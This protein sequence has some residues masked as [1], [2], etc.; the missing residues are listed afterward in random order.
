MERNNKFYNGIPHNDKAPSFRKETDRHIRNRK[1]WLLLAV[2]LSIVADGVVSA[3][4]GTATK[5]DYYWLAPLGLAIVDL[6]LFVDLFFVNL[7]Q[8]YA[9]AHRTLFVL[10][11]LALLAAS[12]V[13]P[14]FDP[15]HTVL[16]LVAAVLIGVVQTVKIVVVLILS[17]V[18]KH[19]TFDFARRAWSIALTLLVG[20][21]LTTYVGLNFEYGFMGQRVSYF[22]KKCTLVFALDE[23]D[24]Y[25]VVDCYADGNVIDVPQ[26]FNGKKVTSL[27][28]T[29]LQHDYITQIDLHGGDFYFAN[30]HL[31][32]LSADRELV[33]NA[34][35]DQV[36]ALRRSL[37]ADA[38]TVASVSQSAR[39][40]FNA[41]R[42]ADLGP[43]ETYY[44]ISF[45][46]VYPKDKLRYFATIIKRADEPFALAD[47]SAAEDTDYLA[48]NDLQSQADLQW[49][50]QYNDGYV[51]ADESAHDGKV[52]LAFEQVYKM[53]LGEGNDAVWHMPAEYETLY[54]ASSQLAERF[55]SLPR[56]DGFDV[57]WLA[58]TETDT[59]DSAQA[60][61]R[62]F[63][64]TA[65]T[66]VT[67]SPRWEVLP[68][69]ILEVSSDKDFAL[70]YGEDT[71]LT[72]TAEAALPVYYT[73]S[74]D[75]AALATSDVGSFDL[76][77]MRPADSGLYTI[78]AICKD[79]D[80]TSLVS[81][82][83]QYAFALQIS[84]RK[85]RLDWLLPDGEFDN[86]DRPIVCD[87]H[88]EDVI[89]GDVVGLALDKYSVF[90][91][92][93]YTVSA[94]LQKDDAANYY[95]EQEDAVQTFSVLPKTIDVVWTDEGEYVYDGT[96]LSPIA[97]TSVFGQ[98]QRLTVMGAGVDAGE[99]IATALAI[100][101]NYTI[102][103]GETHRYTILPKPVQV[104]E[105]SDSAYTYDG[106]VHSPAVLSLTG[107]IA[108]DEQTALA[109]LRY[110]GDTQSIAAGSYAIEVSFA[111]GS[112]YRFDE[113]PVWPYVIARKTIEVAEWDAISFV[114]SAQAQKPAVVRLEGCVSGEENATMAALLYSDWS[115]HIDRNA[116][117]TVAVRLPD[118]TNY[119]FA[120][121]QSVTYAILP[122]P[123]A[124]EW[125][126]AA[127]VYTG[128][129]QAPTPTVT[130]ING[131]VPYSLVGDQI[132]AGEGYIAT[133]S[134]L[135]DNYTLTNISCQYAIAPYA[136]SV[137]WGDVDFVYN[138]NMQAPTAQAIGLA[139]EAISIEVAGGHTDAGAHYTALASVEANANYT[140]ANSQIDYS[141]APLNV[142][143]VWGNAVLVYNG[144]RQAPSATLTGLGGYQVPYRLA[145][146][147][148]DAGT[149]YTAYVEAEDAN[150]LADNAS[151]TYDILPLGIDVEWGDL[152][153]P[154]DGDAHAPAATA[155]RLDGSALTIT[156]GPAA[157]DVGE[158]Y[159]AVAAIQGDA[160]YYIRNDSTTFAIV[161]RPIEAVWGNLSF[162]YNGKA[163][164]PTATAIG[165]KGKRLTLSV[166]ASATDVG[167]YYALAILDDDNYD[168]SNTVAQY[169][170]TPKA[171]TVYW[172]D[173]TLVYNGTLQVPAALAYGVDGGHVQLL[174]EGEQ[175]ATGSDYTA[176][177]RTDN[178]NYT[179]DN[180]STAFAIVPKAATLRWSQ[181][182]DEE[183]VYSGTTKSLSATVA[184]LAEGDQC[185]VTVAVTAG[186]DARNAGAFS[187]TATALSN[188]NY[189]LEGGIGTTSRQYVI[190]PKALTIT[191]GDNTVTYGDEAQYGGMSHEGLVDGDTLLSIG[192]NAT[193]TSAYS[194]G[195]DVGNYEISCNYLPP[196]NYAVSV[197]TGVLTV[198]AKPIDVIWSNLALTYNGLSQ[199][200]TATPTDVIGT[201]EVTLVV[202]GAERNAGT[203]T[204]TVTGISS[205]N[206]V[207]AAGA[208]LTQDYTIAPL[209]MTIAVEDCSVCYG[210]D[211]PDF[212]VRY[213]SFA[214]GDS[215]QTLS[216]LPI[217][218]CDYTPGDDVGEYAITIAGA[219]DPNYTFAYQGGTLT[220]NA[221]ERTLPVVQIE[222]WTYGE[223][224]AQPRVLGEVEEAEQ[225]TVVFYYRAIGGEWTTD[226]PT[227]AGEY[228]VKAVLG[229]TGHYL[230]AESE[231]VAFAIEEA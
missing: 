227:E 101:D 113:A 34:P 199:I 104:A 168:L 82:E 224:A 174:T 63:A 137:E 62:Y 14:T 20:A 47:L 118:D 66:E 132:D 223:D 112:N 142:S 182:T 27:D 157:T 181:L 200:A 75:G 76:L 128:T 216:T 78:G 85:V 65:S 207:P 53:Q 175:K 225:T 12:L 69:T 89:N 86:T 25:R 94:T 198:V 45:G 93:V 178:A 167:Q 194:A 152:S 156:V 191:V 222:S 10:L 230:G 219:T 49:C 121:E 189:T 74:K 91:A 231:A 226:V 115:D 98:T 163:Q 106:A 6:A 206:Y 114:Y 90:D 24:E 77:Q 146:D 122:K 26:T 165:A 133:I 44:N 64:R 68:P 116:E 95:L 79:A 185:T 58:D 59:V 111:Q 147:Q 135:D 214:A 176:T 35:R 161:P 3:L 56:R 171:V 54:F 16:S 150:Y 190:S 153:I 136:L 166:N 96:R 119:A 28:C 103:E 60:L 40:L 155:D 61:A 100:D 184:N 5:G 83:V 84:P 81:P 108:D 48:H 71:G 99:Y 186:M 159:E 19:P 195:S 38:W 131:Q 217:A 204:A 229:A 209:A 172:G 52:S 50:Y 39:V 202:S 151:C 31:S 29:A 1:L 201:D 36:D 120:A 162:V 138:G 210:D 183:L 127:L 92:G 134:S 145:G 205:A 8:K 187:Y 88:A 102:G 32:T 164:R 211:A 33:V 148:T 42:P 126:N 170:I 11:S 149:G 141:I 73:L 197:Q 51:L 129:A 221:K 15:Q 196:Q 177:V 125:G 37:F 130:G 188:A 228:E 43:N 213:Q 110:A 23:N 212:G 218:V 18:G 13:A 4:L 57:T 144:Q 160:N 67:L 30:A 220:V 193:L 97:E 80:V 215:E 154:Y 72:I 124:V 140:V 2:G 22:D 208:Q 158:E 123:I 70:T 46:D 203:Y 192:L 143:T 9:A 109:A 169:S 179:L 55:A 139:G 180:A 105:W 117:Y 173:T 87:L 41:V 7:Q 107:T 17:V 21:V